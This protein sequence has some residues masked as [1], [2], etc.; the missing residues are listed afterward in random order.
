MTW[1]YA[2]LTFHEQTL[3]SFFL[4]NRKPVQSDAAAL[5][6]FLASLA[7]VMRAPVFMITCLP[8]QWRYHFYHHCKFQYFSAEHIINCHIFCFLL[9]STEAQYAYK[10]EKDIVPLLLERG[11]EADGWLGFI[12]GVK[13]FFEFT[14]KYPFQ[15]KSDGL[16]KQL[17]MIYGKK[18]DEK[19]IVPVSVKPVKFSD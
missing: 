5:F 16:R 14:D 1:I 13:L 7:N 18:V 9:L 10:L 2:N 11:Y 19:V 4:S 12:L 3:K 6:C 8:P 17:N 15:E